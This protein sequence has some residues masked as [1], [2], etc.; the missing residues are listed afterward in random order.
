MTKKLTKDEISV[1]RTVL[2][3]V[4]DCLEKQ[5]GESENSEHLYH[6]NYM[7]FILSMNKE[8]YKYFLSAIKKI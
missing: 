2:S 7:N 8:E 6:A 5:E 3:N 4:N 1:L